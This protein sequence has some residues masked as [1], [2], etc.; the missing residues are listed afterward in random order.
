MWDFNNVQIRDPR[1]VEDFRAIGIFTNF[2]QLNE[3]TTVILATE[4]YR[5]V[6]RI[7]Q[8]NRE[9]GIDFQ[10]SPI[11]YFGVFSEC[12]LSKV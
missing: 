9:Q 1:R 12:F 6:C 4:N 5:I 8:G 3:S 10:Q 2:D 7:E 11:A